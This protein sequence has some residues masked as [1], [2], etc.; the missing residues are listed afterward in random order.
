MTFYIVV[1]IFFVHLQAVISIDR[2]LYYVHIV[3]N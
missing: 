2:T 1:S 3:Y